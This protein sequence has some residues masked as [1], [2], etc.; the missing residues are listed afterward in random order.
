MDQKGP[1]TD[2]PAQEPDNR[3]QCR[4]EKEIAADC[5]TQILFHGNPS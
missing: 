3:E 1:L 5:V 2:A 4:D